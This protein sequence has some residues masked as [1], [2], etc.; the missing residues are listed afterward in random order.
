[1]RQR[2]QQWLADS[3]HAPPPVDMGS[4]LLMFA[5]PFVPLDQR[6]EDRFALKLRT[7]LPGSVEGCRAAPGNRVVMLD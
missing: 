5:A 6:R 7:S 4:Q 1:L 2:A 3:G